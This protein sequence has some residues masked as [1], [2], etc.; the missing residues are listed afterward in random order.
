LGDGP[1]SCAGLTWMTQQVLALPLLRKVHLP[2][3]LVTLQKS[4]KAQ[5]S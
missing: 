4:P 5:R 3:E 2:R 1:R